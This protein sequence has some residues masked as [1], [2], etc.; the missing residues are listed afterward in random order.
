MIKYQVRSKDLID[1]VNDVRSGRLI[2]SPYF[3]RNLVWRDIH[4]RDFIETIFKGYPFPQ[5]FVARGEINVESMTSQSCVVDGQQRM[6]AIMEFI[7]DRYPVNGKKYSEMDQGE[8]EDFLKYQIPVIDLEMKA[9]DQS[10]IDVFQRLNRTFYSLSSIEKLS[11]EYSSVD[12]MLIAKYLCGFFGQLDEQADIELM[13]DP[14]MPP[15]FLPWARQFDVSDYRNIVTGGNV[16]SGYENS[17]MVH[18]MWTLNFLSTVR[19]GFFARNDKSREL[20]E[21]T[22]EAT[23]NRE[24]ILANTQRAATFVNSLELPASSIWWNKSNSFSLMILA[25]W[26]IDL[27]ERKDRAAIRAALDGFA[28][29]IPEDYALAAREAVNNLRQRRF[30]HAKLAE[31]LGLD[32][33][34]RP[35]EG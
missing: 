12:F 19:V 29:N 4:K 3:Q 26:N 27:L 28:E 8:K 31:V 33:I 15:D 35:L 10:V 23:P 5:I 16:F 34:E 24:L 25:F 2:L 11:T 6:N 30:R 20:L 18:L 13:Q 1:M 21:A 9:T 17:R 14:N 22:S 32:P 7:K